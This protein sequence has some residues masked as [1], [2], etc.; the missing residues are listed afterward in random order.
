M[1]AI[2][3]A[4]VVLAAER[5]QLQKTEGS[6]LA[7]ARESVLT[8]V[9]PD[10]LLIETSGLELKRLL[11]LLL[12]IEVRGGLLRIKIQEDPGIK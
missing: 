5:K 6:P 3:L 1:T 4:P 12:C 10:P 11:D 7:I 9:A 8:G 2:S